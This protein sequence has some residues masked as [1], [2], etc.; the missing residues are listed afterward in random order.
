[1]LDKMVSI[2]EDRVLPLVR[3]PQGDPTRIRNIQVGWAVWVCRYPDKVPNRRLR[4]LKA[5]R[6]EEVPS[7]ISCKS[8]QEGDILWDKESNRRVVVEAA[9]TG[10]D[11]A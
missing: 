6:R 2:L 9:A 1:M 8:V 10:E 4:H 11:K 7:D 3:R 5:H